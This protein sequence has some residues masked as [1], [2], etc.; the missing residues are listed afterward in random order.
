MILSPQSCHSMPELRVQI[1]ALDAEII[2]LLQKRAAYI[3]RA[4]AIKQSQDLPA[5]IEWRVEEVLAKARENA[6]KAGL[7][8]QLAQTLW[9]EMIE[10]S[11]RKEAATLGEDAI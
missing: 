4:A 7:D 3:T 11:I 9:R 10:W 6:Q 5:R 1:D 2:T 8:P